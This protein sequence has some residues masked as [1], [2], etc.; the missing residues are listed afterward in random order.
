MMEKLLAAVAQGS[1][2][3][4]YL[5]HGDLVLAEPAARRLADALAAA[6]GCEVEIRRQPPRLT[7]L[8][9]DLRT[10]SL[11][12]SAK[13]VLAVNTAALADRASAAELIDDAE[14]A[15]PLG[16]GGELPAGARPGASR[17]IQALKLFDLDPWSSDP[18]RLIQELPRWALE[19]GRT[20]RSRR[21][22]GRTKKEVEA[23]T[24]GL[25]QLLA[26]AG[27]EGLTGWAE[28]GIAVLSS[29][30]RE[31]LPPGHA[32]VLAERS[33]A[34]DHPVVTALVERGAVLEMGEVASEKGGG[35]R[36]LDALSQVLGEETGVGITRD[37]LEEL[38][39]RT[40]RQED[41]QA[42]AAAD[43]TA[44]LAAE[45]RKLAHLARAEGARGEGGRGRG[46]RID[47]R[48]VEEAVED[49][50]QEDVWQLLDAVGGGRPGEALDRLR[51]LLAAADD[52][53]SARLSFFGLVASFCR[54]LTAIRGMML[55]AGVRSGE[56]HY[57][58]FKDR[59]APKL[60]GPLPDG[61][62]NPLAGLHPYRLHRAYLAAGRIPE[63]DAALLP[64][65]VLQTEIQLKGGSSDPDGALAG[66][67]AHLATAGK[68]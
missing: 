7:P 62:S 10:F 66:L 11:F 65:R 14:S 22:R 29:A 59:V 5:V 60:Q 13:V 19:G 67:L 38:A 15:L 36:G 25:A 34:R 42:P 28:D 40:L 9:D 21:P 63:E 49:R 64:W 57:G 18:E 17:L 52:P 46:P 55:L 32:L 45:Y 47:R 26:A 31:G 2:Q 27:D 4:V 20:L 48:M 16:E 53:V 51:R 68:R 39:R 1:A 54:Q 33:V 50:G 6:A 41:R 56:S 43:S 35:W 37:A 8:L 44:R 3:P 23:L 61:R 24:A 58:R 30:V 12:A